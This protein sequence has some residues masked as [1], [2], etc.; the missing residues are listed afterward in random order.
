MP[1]LSGYACLLCLLLSASPA[2]SVTYDLNP[3]TGADSN[4][5]TQA[6][7]WKTLN[8]VASSVGPGDTVTVQAGTY[9]PSQYVQGGGYFTWGASHAH[10]RAGAPITLQG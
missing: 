10:G 5:G 6:A 8:K 7:P 1:R 2:W 3:A 4:P 9:T